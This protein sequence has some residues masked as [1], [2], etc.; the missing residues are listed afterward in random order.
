MYQ[1]ISEVL[2]ALVRHDREIEEFLRLL[3][4]SKDGEGTLQKRLQ[5]GQERTP[6]AHNS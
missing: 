4:R 3:A 1:K 5:R 6:S 2:C